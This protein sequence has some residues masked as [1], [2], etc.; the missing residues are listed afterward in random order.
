MLNKEAGFGLTLPQAFIIESILLVSSL[1]D[2]FVKNPL[3]EEFSMVWFNVAENDDAYHFSFHE[4]D[5]SLF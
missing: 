5:S 1:K 3:E 4:K 2:D